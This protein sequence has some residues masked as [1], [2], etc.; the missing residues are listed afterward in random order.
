[1]H[2]VIGLRTD[3]SVSFHGCQKRRHRA[4]VAVYTWTQHEAITDLSGQACWL[5]LWE[6]PRRGRLK[7]A[8]YDDV[9][10]WVLVYVRFVQNVQKLIRKF[11]AIRHSYFLLIDFHSFSS[12][13][14]TEW[15]S[16]IIS[17]PCSYRNVFDVYTIKLDETRGMALLLPKWKPK[18]LGSS[19]LNVPESESW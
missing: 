4:C 10:R 1:M 8:S 12:T 11:K 15:T 17:D 18:Y 6:K 19:L 9:L 7:G 16:W 14:L 2:G 5:I 13:R 3:S